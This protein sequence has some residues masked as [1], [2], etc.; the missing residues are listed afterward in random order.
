MNLSTSFSCQTK[1]LYVAKKDGYV[2]SWQGPAGF[3]TVKALPHPLLDFASGTAHQLALN[4]KN[5]VYGWG[6][7][8]SA[9]LGL[10]LFG[11]SYCLDPHKIK[12][13]MGSDKIISVHA[14]ENSSYAI[15]E[16]G[17]LWVWGRN[18]NKQLGLEQPLKVVTPQEGPPFPTPLVDLAPGTCHVVALTQDGTIWTFG[19]NRDGLL[20]AQETV[21]WSHTP[22]QLSLPPATRVFAGS[23]I[24]AMTTEEGALYVWG[25]KAYSLL[26]KTADTL[27]LPSFQPHLIFPSGVLEVA[28]GVSHIVVLLED[29]SIWGWGNNWDDQLGGGGSP[30]SLPK[31][32][33]LPN[34]QG[35]ISGIIAGANFSAA[36]T[37]KRVL[38]VIGKPV[39]YLGVTVKKFTTCPVYVPLPF[40]RK[41]EWEKLFKWMFLGKQDQGA[42]F[43]MMPDE[44]M[45]NLVS[46]WFVK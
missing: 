21:C 20:G 10:G 39:A 5:K 13:P 32:I 33:E 42:V 45:F 19:N 28:C 26:A 3:L 15:T 6:D 29:N 37:E 14:Y 12:I 25:S 23:T 2:V 11:P 17:K 31:K 36:F 34:L 46:L 9:Q 24:S 44:V 4:H 18:E 16:S 38:Y 27:R 30:V 40:S 1:K 7:N 43:Y 41:K 35:K 8:T 22:I